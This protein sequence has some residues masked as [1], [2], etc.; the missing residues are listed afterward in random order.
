[1]F[2]MHLISDIIDGGQVCESPPYQA[3]C[4]IRA[5]APT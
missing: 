2:E 3:K 4:K 5:P 1:M